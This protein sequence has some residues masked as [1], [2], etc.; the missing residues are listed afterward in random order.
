MNAPLADQL[1]ALAGTHGTAR[2]LV[3]DGARLC[4]GRFA[5]LRA[6]GLS[7]VGADLR[8]GLLAQARWKECVLRDACIEAADFSGAVLRRCDLDGVRAA[9]ARFT[10]ARI[11]NCRAQGARFDAADLGRAVLTDSDFSRA[12][13]RDADL[14][15][16]AA[17]GACFRGA[18]LAGAILRNA[19]LT[20]ADLRGADLTGATLAGATFDGADLRGA[21]GVD[22]VAQDDPAVAVLPSEF[23]VEF[24]DE[25]PTEFPAEF[26]DELPDELR[27]LAGSVAPIVLEVLRS[28]GRQGA[29]GPDTVA[30]LAAE[31]QALAGPATARTPPHAD[32]LRAVSRV[33]E[34]LGGDDLGA[35]FS[36]LQAPAGGQPPEQVQRLIRRLGREL[37]LD[38]NAGAERILEQLTRR[39]D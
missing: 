5:G 29:I 32:T 18:D 35:L 15:G 34:E 36:L 12:S 28:G 22:A 10:G 19:D 1:Q 6:D 24:P 13:F 38:D 4:G 7:L 8:D 30:R 39:P 31:V 37:Q 9:G 17:S 11:E 16:V 2:D 14:D 26:P 20:D 23:P 33:L 25:L 27:T 3:L 21:T